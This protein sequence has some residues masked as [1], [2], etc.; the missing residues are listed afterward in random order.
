MQ[1]R[2]SILKAMLCAAVLGWPALPIRTATGQPA[3]AQT[4]A[5]QAPAAGEALTTE[6]PAP[7]PKSEEAAHQLL[8]GNATQAIAHYTESLKDTGLAN[9][10]R[11]ALLNDRAVAYVRTG[12]PKLALEDYNRAVQ[13]FAEYPAAYNNRGNLLVT[14]SQPNEAMK[15]FD[16]AI[17]LAPG[18]AAAYSNRANARLKLGE[19]AAALADFTKAIELMP[20]SAPP[21]SGRGLAHLMTGKPHA[22]IRDFSRA[23]NA[24]ARFASAYRNRA[25]AR[26]SVAQND[27]AIEDLSRAI[28]FDVNNAEI[29]VVR[30]YAY[31]ATSNAPS[32]IK[33]FSRAIELDQRSVA[34]YQ[35]RGLANGIAEAY[36]E[37]YADLNRAI[38]LEPRSATSFAYRAFVYKQNAQPDVGQRDVESAVK[39]DPNAAPTIWARA[40]IAEARGQPEAAIADF[41]KALAV[42]PGWRL[43]SEGLKR[44]GAT[45]NAAED[46]EMNGLGVDD[47]K[48]V[49]RGQSY[50]AISDNYPQL[51]I[52]LEMMGEGKPQLL[53]W[54][55]KTPPH[56]GYGVLR[57]SGGK[58][59]TKTGPE[60]TEL[61]AIIDIE[62]ARVLAIQ[63]HRQGVRVA[64]WTWEEDRVQIASVDGVTDEF[65]VRSAKAR[66]TPVAAQPAPDRPR[67]TAQGASKPST[68]APW[69]QPMGTPK[70]ERREQ[71]RTSQK[72]KTLFELLFN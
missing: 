65:A 67:R 41:Q 64:A 17:L 63:P 15:D 5:D 31:L 28:A 10:R 9:D 56:K 57:F 34:A 30:G 72:P 68:W 53:A 22:A 66:E 55:L 58:V 45:S 21:L 50:F 24:D 16:R 11:A 7:L 23:V 20:Q 13:I 12:Q 69:D 18:Y 48:V 37:A 19:Q 14:L 2:S 38:E 61:A 35:A 59:A 40:E 29:Y 60:E 71:R 6:T 70:S 62:S 8:Q 44:L 54:E 52:P 36:E 1:A 33:D 4:P 3:P 27:E 43:A 32:A 49:Q 39:L 25:E 46:V 42:D 26:I 47:W 51:R